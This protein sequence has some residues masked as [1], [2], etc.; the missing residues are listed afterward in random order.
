MAVRAKLKQVAK[1]RLKDKE[2]LEAVDWMDDGLQVKLKV[3]I[4]KET[5]DAVFDFTGT[6]PEF[7]G[8]LNAPEAVTSSAVIYSLRCLVA[9]NIP[10]ND[11]CMLPVKIIIPKGSFLSPSDTAGVVGGNVLTSQ[12]VTDVILTAFGAQACSQGC[13]NNFTF[14]GDGC[15][16]YYETIAGGNG[17]G[18]T[19]NGTDATQCHMTNTRITDPEILERRFPVV[20][21]EFSIRRGS[22]GKGKFNGGNGVTRRVKFL[23]K[24]TFSILSERRSLAPRGYAG[25]EDGQK[26]LN[27]WIRNPGTPEERIIHFGSKNSTVASP[28]DVFVIAT[29]GGGGYGQQ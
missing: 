1:E 17:A 20:L 12:R 16:S 25:G 27:L 15:P 7:Y 18:P 21:E 22:G 4:D 28:G 6:S 2:Y 10:L 19:W 14:G 8:N 29:P 26:G 5:G 24:M 11:G 23:R 9:D 13:M 3:Q